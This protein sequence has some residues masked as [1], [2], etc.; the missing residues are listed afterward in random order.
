MKGRPVEAIGVGLVGGALAGLVGWPL[1]I[2]IL[3]AAVGV[4]NGLVSGWFGIYR[5]RYKRGW[6]ALVLDSTWGLVGTTFGLGLHLINLFVP[7]AE[8]EA[9]LSNRRDRHV[10][11]RGM[12]IRPGFTLSMGNVVSNAGGRVGLRGLAA[13]VARRRH[14]VTAHEELHVWQNRWF[15]PIFQIVY[16]SWLIVGAVVGALAWPFVGGKWWNAIETVAYYDNPFEF[17]AYSNDDYWPPRGVHP[18]LT[19]RRRVT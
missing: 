4:V 19:W 18:R 3:T 5:L 17:W 15:G 6:V 7:G 8:Y 2:E 14:F 16:G 9:Q 11:S 13:P 12:T 10:Y 1:G